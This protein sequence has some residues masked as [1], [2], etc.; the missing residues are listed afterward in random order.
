M[1][2]RVY[3]ETTIVSYL[4][5]RPSR[6]VVLKAHQ[7]LTHDWWTEERPRYDLCVSPLVVREASAG[8]ARMAGLRLSALHD[9]PLLEITS[10]A[11]ELAR[12]LI[13]RGSLP[14][15]AEADA[16]HIALAAVHGVEFLLTWNCKHI[17]NAR[18][19]PRIETL[20]RAAGYSPP[21]L[22]T[23]EELTGT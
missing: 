21:I 3:V 1:K 5:A 8:D 10:D 14:S 9:V 16:L 20:C 15:K 12:T 6:D 11:T 22:C 13:E 4:V 18:M 7:Q 23:P 17:A 2:P 19:R